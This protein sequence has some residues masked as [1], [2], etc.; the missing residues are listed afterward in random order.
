MNTFDKIVLASVDEEGVFKC[1]QFNY[2]STSSDHR[3]LTISGRASDANLGGVSNL[4]N[5]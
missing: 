4:T 5:R 1:N 2:E 3:Q